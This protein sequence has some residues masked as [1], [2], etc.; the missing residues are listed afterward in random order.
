[1]HRRDL[2]LRAPD[3]FPLGATLFSAESPRGVV[4]VSPATGAPRGFYRAY[5]AHV[6]GRGFSVLTYDYRGIGGS[7]PS[8]GLRGF[9]A[10]MRDWGRLDFAGALAWTRQELP[11]GPRFVVAHSVGF[12]LLGLTPEVERLDGIVG[13]APPSG[14]W[15]LYPP[16]H[17]YVLALLWYLVGPLLSRLLGYFPSGLI[18][19][20]E[21]LPRGVMEEWCAWC[22]HPDYLF[23]HVSKETLE[24]YRRLDLP[25]FV[26]GFSDDVIAPPASVHSLLDHFPA[27]DVHERWVEP[28][29]L[30]VDRIGHFGFFRE[31]LGEPLWEATTRWMEAR[32]P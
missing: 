18:G 6:R 25:A 13:V 10:R 32:G 30:G 26:L 4:V 27:L 19:F 3:G 11:P 20:G 28:A 14:Y 16:A 17:R 21:E 12:Q 5:A 31:G 22:R 29:E 23:G 7:R 24:R 2:E 9:Q 1:M 15:R 8:G